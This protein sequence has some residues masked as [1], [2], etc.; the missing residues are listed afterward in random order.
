VR[1]KLFWRNPDD[2]GACLTVGKHEL[3]DKHDYDRALPLLAK[4]GHAVLS[5]WQART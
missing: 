1:I 3:F 4:S 5:K 2:P